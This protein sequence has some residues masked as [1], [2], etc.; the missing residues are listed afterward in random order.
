MKNSKIKKKLNIKYIID[1]NFLNIYRRSDYLTE[2]IL[3]V[4]GEDN[5][6]YKKNGAVEN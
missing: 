4:V 2:N 6:V 5:N 1:S 3:F